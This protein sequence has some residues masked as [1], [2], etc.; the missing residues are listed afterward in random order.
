MPVVRVTSKG[1]ATLPKELRERLGIK[2]PGRVLVWEEDGRLVVM[3]YRKPSEMQA[4]WARVF[5]GGP[6]LAELR[7]EEAAA[8]RRREARLGGA[9]RRA[10]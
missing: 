7:A 3:P 6:S 9:G 1:Q 2:A 4:H 8:E 10:R 5:A